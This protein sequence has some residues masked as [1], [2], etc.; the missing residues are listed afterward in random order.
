MTYLARQIC[1]VDSNTS[2]GTVPFSPDGRW[3]ATSERVFAP[4]TGAQRCAL[5]RSGFGGVAFSPDGNRAVTSTYQGPAV[6]MFNAVS[7]A[8]QWR[9]RHDQSAYA[10]RWSPNGQRVGVCIGA[11]VLVL[12]SATGAEVCRCANLGEP[13]QNVDFSWSPDSTGIAVAHAVGFFAPGPGGVRFFDAATGSQQRRIDLEGVFNK[14]DWSADGRLV[15]VGGD[16]GAV[17]VDAAT[18]TLLRRLIDPVGGETALVQDIRLDRNGNRAVT[19]GRDGIAR[20]FNTTTGDLLSSF[21]HG[22]EA[23]SALFSPDGRWVATSGRAGAVLFDPVNGAERCRLARTQA[24]P[25]SFSPDGSRTSVGTYLRARIVDPAVPQARLSIVHGGAVN[26]VA[27][28]PDGRWVATGSADGTARV[29]DS[30]TGNEHSRLTHGGPVRSLVFGPDGQWVATGSDDTTARVFDTDTGVQKARFEHD[31]KVLTVVASE[32]GAILA[33]GSEDGILR[34]FGTAGLTQRFRR[35]HGGAVH[36]VAISRDG[37]LVATGCTDGSARVFT[38]QSGAERR[39]FAHNGVVRSV[40]FTPDGAALATACTDGLVRLFHIDSGQELLSLEH[41]DPTCDEG[42]RTEVDTVA[43]S[44]TGTVLATGAYSRLRLFTLPSGDLQTVV[45]Q[46]T[47]IAPIVFSADGT[48]LA[49]ASDR[50][51]GAVYELDGTQR[52]VIEHDAAARW[53]ALAPDATWFVTGSDDAT[54][55]VGDIG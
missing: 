47:R 15:G 52:A 43:I 21:D 37:D 35:L 20:V 4:T 8:E 17:L 7:G 54:A 55:R 14:T 41:P 51:T 49:A 29:L 44:P 9:V 31:G 1:A 6:V 27:A 39:Q 19:A 48:L 53:I 34:V 24:G 22:D 45:H 5:L 30:R 2:D 18:A 13:D 25:V 36:S 11:A 3:A 10:L 26:A 40:A 12:D 23:Y 38:T 42:L 46:A 16:S 32:N 33:T 50:G 28:S